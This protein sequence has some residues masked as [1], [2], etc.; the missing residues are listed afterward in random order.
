MASKLQLLVERAC[1]NLGV[2]EEIAAK[3][4]NFIDMQKIKGMTEPY[5]SSRFGDYL[6]FLQIPDT[7]PMQQFFSER[8]ADHV[9]WSQV[10]NAY[11]KFLNME[12]PAF[13]PSRL[14]PQYQDKPFYQQ[15][16][17]QAKLGDNYDPGTGGAVREVAR[18][19]DLY[20]NF[21]IYEFLPDYFYMEVPNDWVATL[22]Q[23]GL[24]ETDDSKPY[25]LAMSIEEARTELQKKLYNELHSV[26]TK[27]QLLRYTLIA[28]D[29]AQLELNNDV[30]YPSNAAYR[31]S[32][33]SIG[34]YYT[35][36][37]PASAISIAHENIT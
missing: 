17:P 37:I 19:E 34:H 20:T 16:L 1:A 14:E 22:L 33:R 9:V 29:P 35:G 25:S 21:I 23:E 8:W 27:T 28:I 36:A 24:P 3:L 2:P 5:A 10:P 26:V 15:G 4:V 6:G 31:R 32:A 12:M 11:M 7:A 13:T 30:F 18:G